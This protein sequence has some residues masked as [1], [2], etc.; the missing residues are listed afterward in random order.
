ML[1][2]ISLDTHRRVMYQV[3]VN[4][5]YYTSSLVIYCF[6]WQ[7]KA[8]CQ[9][10]SSDRVLDGVVATSAKHSN[11]YLQASLKGLQ[12]LFESHYLT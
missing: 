3:C 9:V 12:G 10:F 1:S 6:E 7:P 11:L 2:I 4:I 8:D 5:Y